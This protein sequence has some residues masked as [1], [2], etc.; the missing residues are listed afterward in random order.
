MNNKSRTFTSTSS[1]SIGIGSAVLDTWMKSVCNTLH[2]EIS[3][4]EDFNGA[5]VAFLPSQVAKITGIPCT[6]WNTKCI[7]TECEQH[8]QTCKN[9]HTR[10]HTLYYT[11]HASM[12]YAH[13]HHIHTST[14][15]HTHTRTHTHTHLECPLQPV[16][17][18]H[19]WQYPVCCSMCT[20]TILHRF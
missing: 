19:Y 3:A 14:H 6:T 9:M 15:A 20:S 13:T 5:S 10:T 12:S 17:A 1:Y 11:T 7:M 18:S 8:T 2:H 16:F 4:L